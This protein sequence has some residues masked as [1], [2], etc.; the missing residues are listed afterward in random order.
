MPTRAYVSTLCALPFL[1]LSLPCFAQAPDAPATAATTADQCSAAFEE[2][3]RLQTQG[4]LLD[5]QTKLIECSQP[6]CPA[7]LV[8]ECVA[9][10]DRLFKVAEPGKERD[11]LQ[12]INPASRK[13]VDAKLE[14]AMRDSRSGQSFQFERH[15]Y[16][17]ADSDPQTFNRTVTLRDS[18]KA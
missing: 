15:G 9:L 3:Q 16:F 11:F 14:P 7:F 6:S 4:K 18:W 2:G 12:D 5:S 1:L 8:R 17:V 10:Y 13:L